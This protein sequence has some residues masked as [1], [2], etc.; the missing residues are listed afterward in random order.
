MTPR[1]RGPRACAA[2]KIM[3]VDIEKRKRTD[4][5]HK[6]VDRRVPMKRIAKKLGTT[7]TIFPG[8]LQASDDLLQTSPYRQLSHA[9]PRTHPPPPTLQFPQ[10]W[11]VMSCYNQQSPPPIP[12][13]RN[14]ILSFLPYGVKNLTA[15]CTISGRYQVLKSSCRT[16]CFR[17]VGT[18]NAGSGCPP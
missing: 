13:T 15:R 17:G 11:N 7:V 2:L 5:D 6:G 1:P 12:G 10:E 18:I 8:Q 14:A 9:Y 16:N 4:K 3:F